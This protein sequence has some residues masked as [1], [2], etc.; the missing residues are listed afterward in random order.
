MTRRNDIEGGLTLS[1]RE[2]EITD[3]FLLI[4]LEEGFDVPTSARYALSALPDPDP[5]FVQWLTQ[6]S[7]TPQPH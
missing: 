4:M 6:G 3:L 1:L 5:E 7:A 2:H